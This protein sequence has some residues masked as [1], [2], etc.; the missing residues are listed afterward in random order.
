MV[1]LSAR[2]EY[3]NLVEAIGA[4]FHPDTFGAEYESLPDQYSAEDVDRIV[5]AAFEADDIDD[6][7][8][9]AYD[10]LMCEACRTA[11]CLGECLY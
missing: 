4:G 6:P 1:T 5:E 7:Y 9:L 3:E 10:V 2:Q 8:E 11:G